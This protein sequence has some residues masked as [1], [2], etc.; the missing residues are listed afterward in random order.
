MVFHIL[1][2][3]LWRKFTIK[4]LLAP[5]KSITKSENPSVDPIQEACSDFKGTVA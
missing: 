2:A 3:F 4:F 5:L 1:A